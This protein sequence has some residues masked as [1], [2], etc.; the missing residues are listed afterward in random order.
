MDHLA[1]SRSSHNSNDHHRE[2][3]EQDMEE[4]D[5]AGRQLG[6]GRTRVASRMVMETETDNKDTPQADPEVQQVNAPRIHMPH[7]TNVLHHSNSRAIISNS[8]QDLHRVNDPH[9]DM[10]M[11]SEDPTAVDLKDPHRIL[12][13]PPMETKTVIRMATEDP[14]RINSMLLIR[15][16]HLHL[17]TTEPRVRVLMVAVPHPRH[18]MAR[19]DRVAQVALHLLETTMPPDSRVLM[20]AVPHLLRPM[21][22]LDR[23]VQVALLLLETTMLLDNRDLMVETSTNPVSQTETD[24][25]QRLLRPLTAPL[26]KADPTETM[27]KAVDLPVLLPLHMDLLDKADPVVLLNQEIM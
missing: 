7:Q 13:D 20:V 26:A 6:M 11:A 15:T 17:R 23:E 10:E 25:T 14:N 1:S 16:L 18:L 12:T 24:L 27:D 3:M 22:R 9:K 21:A 4:M 19:L 8:V 5:K 2:D